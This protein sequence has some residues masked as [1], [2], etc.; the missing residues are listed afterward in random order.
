MVDRRPLSFH[1][2]VM[3]WRVG[4]LVGFY[5]AGLI[6]GLPAFED[7]LYFDGAF[8]FLTNTEATVVIRPQMYDKTGAL[9]LQT[10]VM[11][12]RSFIIDR[13]NLYRSPIISRYLVES[14]GELLMV[15]R[16]GRGRPL[17]TSEF[18]VFQMQQILD[19][20]NG[21]RFIWVEL[22]DLGGRMIFLSRGCSRSFDVSEFPG[23]SEGVY[24]KSDG[25]YWTD[26]W[27]GL[28]PNQRDALLK[29]TGF[30]SG[31][32]PGNIVQCFTFPPQLPGSLD[33]C[34]PQWFIPGV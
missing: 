34:P 22:D 12:R 13:T 15:V 14:H 8:H 24:F 2:D 21:P 9:Q 33:Y 3:F 4:S 26:R 6:C 5:S 11:E 18:R 10:P 32:V 20:V 29:E 23:F 16:Y 28:N 1:W 31:P 27:D 25:Q 17:V 7:L 30:W 19:P